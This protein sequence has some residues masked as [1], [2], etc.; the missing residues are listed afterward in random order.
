[1]LHGRER[2]VH[3]WHLLLLQQL[4]PGEL[5]HLRE[6][7]LRLGYAADMYILCSVKCI[8]STPHSVV[9]FLFGCGAEFPMGGGGIR[10]IRRTRV[11]AFAFMVYPFLRAV[12][13]VCGHL[14]M[15]ALPPKE[16][17]GN[18]HADG[19]PCCGRQRCRGRQR[20][21]MQVMRTQLCCRFGARAHRRTPFPNIGDT[22][23]R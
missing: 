12:E 2:S 5:H 20:A 9:Q 21:F 22:N 6:R 11:Q 19:R 4:C 13:G 17:H 8:A 7:S 18:R 10:V 14:H 3:T 15:S 23:Y 16:L 1:M